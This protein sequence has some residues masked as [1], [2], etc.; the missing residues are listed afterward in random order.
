MLASYG[1]RSGTDKTI[2]KTQ[3]GKIAYSKEKIIHSFERSG[4]IIAFLQHDYYLKDSKIAN[5][6]SDNLR[7]AFG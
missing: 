7:V 2:N 1:T 5:S 3:K 6:H 4:T